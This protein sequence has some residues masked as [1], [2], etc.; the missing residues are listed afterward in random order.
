MSSR[1]KASLSAA[2]MTVS[3]AALAVCTIDARGSGAPFPATPR[4]ITKVKDDVGREIALPLPLRRV[5]VF[6]RYATEFI[7]AVAGMGVVVG[8]DVNVRKSGSYWPGT[9]ATMIVGESQSNAAPKVSLA[10]ASR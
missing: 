6:N 7:R 5:V 1:S 3:V 8:F 4:P 9:T 2:I 10:Q